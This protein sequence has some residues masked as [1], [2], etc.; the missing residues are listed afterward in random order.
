MQHVTAHPGVRLE[1]DPCKTGPAEVGTYCVDLEAAAVES[2]HEQRIVISASQAQLDTSR[3]Q[4][5]PV[6]GVCGI[7]EP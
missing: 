3:S 2:I 5:L 7:P 1:A 6:R 4:P